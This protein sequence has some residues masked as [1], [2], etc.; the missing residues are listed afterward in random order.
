MSRTFRIILCLTF[1]SLV[2][3]SQDNWKVRRVDVKDAPVAGELS[4]LIKSYEI[5]PLDNNPVAYVSNPGS[6]IFTDSLIL[7]SDGGKR[8]IIFDNSGKY[9]NSISKQGRGPDEYQNINDFFY[10]SSDRL[11]SIIDNDKIKR[12]K[13]NGDFVSEK[14]IGFRANRVTSFGPDSYIIEKV[15][16]S[17]DPI[18]DYYIRLTG[19]DFKTKSARF[20]VKPLT[21]PGFGTEGQRSRTQINGSHAYFFSYFGDTVF[22]IDNESI[23]PVYA[24]K[25][26]K[27]IITVTNGTGEYDFDPEQAYRYLSYIET[28]DLNILFFVYGNR[29][30]A[31]AFNISGSLSK[32]YNASFTIGDVVDGKGVLLMDVMMLGKLIEGM[33]R[34]ITK[35]AN[36]EVLERA[37]SDK[38]NGSQCFIKVSFLPSLPL[39]H[40]D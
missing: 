21:G 16:P 34:E 26:G 4:A 39:S 37:L 33:D 5:L 25:Y 22:H 10:S 14:R 36:R 3:F 8:I 6:K 31:F 17:G 13:L 2:S 40:A 20:P 18:S 9:L 32:T 38:E 35:C 29:S 1:L 12:Y 23:R 11:V 19:K 7:I 24:F 30:Y 28:G 27:K 15:I